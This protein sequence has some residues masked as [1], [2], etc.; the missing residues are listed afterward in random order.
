MML[1][2]M[3]T[4][5]RSVVFLPDVKSQASSDGKCQNWIHLM[6]ITN[7][8][9]EQELLIRQHLTLDK[10]S[11]YRYK[12]MTVPLLPFPLFAREVL[13]RRTPTDSRVV[14]FKVRHPVGDT[15]VKTTNDRLA[16]RYMAQRLFYGFRKHISVLF[17]W[18][19]ANGSIKLI[20]ILLGNI[21][22]WRR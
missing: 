4:S 7:C 9:P 14:V 19:E 21:L 3:V 5:H 8:L 13:W 12:R 10:E 15:P 20:I 11:I 16:L 2:L 6:S 22:C 1:L 17:Y 18:S